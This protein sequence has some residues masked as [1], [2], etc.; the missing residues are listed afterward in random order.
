MDIDVTSSISHRSYY[1][2]I[3]ITRHY[4]VDDSDEAYGFVDMGMTGSVDVRQ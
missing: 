1:R 3:S 4:A 2:L